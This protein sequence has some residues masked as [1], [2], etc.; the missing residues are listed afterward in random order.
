MN[1]VLDPTEYREES[2]SLSKLVQILIS[3]SCCSVWIQLY[4]PSDDRRLEKKRQIIFKFWWK[5]SNASTY[6]EYVKDQDHRRYTID[7]MMDQ[8]KYQMLEVPLIWL[9]QFALKTREKKLQRENVFRKK[10]FTVVFEQPQVIGCPWEGSRP[11][12]TI[13]ENW[14]RPTCE[15]FDDMSFQ[16][17]TLKRRKKNEENE[18]NVS[19]LTGW[20]HRSFLQRRFIINA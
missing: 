3:N 2:R 9:L 10:I 11:F 6:E 17:G 1:S 20:K 16:L 12:R 14:F 7:K 4:R 5:R 19:F 13:N 18:T 8:M 15:L